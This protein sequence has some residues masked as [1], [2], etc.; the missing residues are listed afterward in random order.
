MHHRPGAVGLGGGEHGAVVQRQQT[1][2]GGDAIGEGCHVGEIGQLGLQQPRLDEGIGVAVEG[3]GADL[4]VKVRDCQKLARRQGVSPAQGPVVLPEGAGVG[5]V[6]RSDGAERLPGL[7]GM[8][9]PGKAY[10]QGLSHG[11]GAVGGDVV[12]RAQLGGIHPV[13]GGNGV[14]GLPGPHNM[15]RHGIS[16]LH[17]AMPAGIVLDGFGEK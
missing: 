15:D 11:Q 8:D 14:Q 3:R 10:H 9:L 16:P 12:G 6:G 1:A 2:L 4:L 13:L 5:A 17:Q 7:D